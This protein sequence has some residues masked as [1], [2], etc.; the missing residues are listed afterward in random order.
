MRGTLL[1]QQVDDRLEGI[2]PAH[3]GNTLGIGSGG[4]ADGDHP[5]TCGEHT[6][7]TTT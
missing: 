4:D 6:A 3:A 2:I 7:V 1:A 5:R